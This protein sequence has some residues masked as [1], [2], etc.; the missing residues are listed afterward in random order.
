MSNKEEY[1]Y[2]IFYH[3]FSLYN[4]DMI[5]FFAFLNS[6]GFFTI[7]F[8]AFEAESEWKKKFMS[9]MDLASEKG[10]VPS[11]IEKSIM[12]LWAGLPLVLGWF[13]VEM[14]V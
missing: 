11:D 5:S 2:K 4:P 3:Y 6:D 1:D 7:P 8:K 10:M 12:G 14:L 9:N 13:Y